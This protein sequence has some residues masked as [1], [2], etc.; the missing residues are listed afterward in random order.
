M[1]S[2]EQVYGSGWAAW[3]GK[4][5]TAS[6]V[7]TTISCNVAYLADAGYTRKAAALSMIL[8]GGASLYCFFSRRR[9]INARDL[10]V[11]TGCNS[12]LGYSLA[13]HCRARGA[14][15]LAGVRERGALLNTNAAVKALENNGVIVHHLDVTNEQSARDFRDKVEGLLEER[16]LVLRALVN[17]AGVMVFGEFE[18][19]TQSLV[20]HQVNVNL[21]GTMRIT[22]ELMPTLRANRSRIIVVSSHCAAESLPGISIYGATKAALHAWTTALRVEVGKYGVEVVSF[23]P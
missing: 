16:Q 23:V 10:I 11:I 6:Q 22:R 1:N 14:T 5:W 18:W 4:H 17:N 13:M 21:L 19:Q 15:V 9:K 8:L 7:G 3:W 2:V 12:G 20:E